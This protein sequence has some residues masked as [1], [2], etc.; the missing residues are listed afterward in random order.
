MTKRTGIRNITDYEIRR[1]SDNK[2]VT[3]YCSW[4]DNAGCPG[5]TEG[6]PANAHMQALLHRAIR[7]G[8]YIQQRTW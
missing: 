1:Y 6:E 3:A 4:V 8:V 2:Q 5:R 7:E